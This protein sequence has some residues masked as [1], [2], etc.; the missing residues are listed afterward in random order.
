M[1][2]K[3]STSIPGAPLPTSAKY[4]ERSKYLAEALKGGHVAGQR[5]TGG[6]G[7]LGA[8]LLAQAVLGRAQAKNS[9]ESH[10]KTKS[11]YSSIRSTADW[12]V[13]RTSW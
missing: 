6:W 1:A 13:A 11:G 9:D 5:I 10:V 12:N 8:R 7:E 4:A 3:Q 2:T